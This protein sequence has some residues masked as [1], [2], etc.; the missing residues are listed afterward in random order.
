MNQQILKIVIL[1][2]QKAAA[3]VEYSPKYGA[4]CPECGKEKIPVIK[5]NPWIDDVKIRHHRCDNPHCILATMEETIKSYQE[6]SVPPPKKP[7]KK[8]KKGKPKVKQSKAAKKA[9][10]KNKPQKVAIFPE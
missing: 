1:A 8:R 7:R 5:N 10:S 6:N 2:R 4:I 3:G 9:K